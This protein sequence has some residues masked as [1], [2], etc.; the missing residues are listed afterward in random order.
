MRYEMKNEYYIY[1]AIVDSDMDKLSN[2]DITLS[3]FNDFINSVK[4]GDDV[5]FVFNSPGG[6]VTSGIAIA[7]KIKELSKRGIKTTAKIEGVCASISTCIACACEKIVM[8]NG[9]FF[10]IHN[11]WSFVQGDCN[12]L[13]KEADLMEKMNEAILSFY[14]SKFN[15]TD[16]QLKKWMNEE[17]WISSEDVNDFGLICE[18][19]PN[20][21]Q[22]KIAACI[23]RTSFNKIP[24]KL[25]HLISDDI[26]SKKIKNKTEVKNQENSENP[27]KITKTTELTEKTEETEFKIPENPGST[28]N[29]DKTIDPEDPKEPME[30][31]ESNKCTEQKEETKSQD[32]DCPNEDDPEVLKFRIK[33]LETEIE[34]LKEKLENEEEMVSKNECEKRVSGMQASMQKQINDFVNQLKVKNEEL[35][36]SKNEITS[37]KKDIETSNSELSSIKSELEKTASALVDKTNKLDALNAGVL[38]TPDKVVDWRNLKGKEFWNFLKQHPEIKN[39]N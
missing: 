8:C 7:N 25:K 27:V 1:G 17:T 35:I 19:V 14:R 33:E 9:S 10:M 12:T 21:K 20:E 13:R 22:L 16:E 29:P 2:D 24:T 11:C 4:D 38:K 28:E 34:K 5:T 6:L 31:T 36:S 15:A 18:V 37:L 39:A 3:D 23:L 30:P 32:P 26:M